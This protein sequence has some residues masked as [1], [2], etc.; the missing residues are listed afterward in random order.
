MRLIAINRLTGGSIVFLA[1]RK[2]L[3]KMTVIVH[4][5]NI[6]QKICNI[7][8][9]QSLFYTYFHTKGGRIWWII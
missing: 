8:T 9:L 2:D 7:H 3:L 1:K 6:L 4:Y 5:Y